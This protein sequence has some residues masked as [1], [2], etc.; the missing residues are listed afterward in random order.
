MYLKPKV[1]RASK[2]KAAT[3]DRT[4][5]HLVNAAAIEALREYALDLDAVAKCA[6]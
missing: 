5:S 6:R 1:Y 3:T 2:V 4:S